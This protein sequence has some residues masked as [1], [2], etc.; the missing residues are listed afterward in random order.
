MKK[1]VLSI[2]FLT[3]T[4]VTSACTNPSMEDGLSRLDVALAEL[5]AAIEAINIPQMQEDLTAMNVMADQILADAQAAQLNFEQILSEL[6]QA[7]AILEGIVQ[8]SSSWAT[9]EDIAIIQAQVDEFEIGVDTLVAI[10]DYDHDGVINA[11][12]KCPD[13]PLGATVNAV[14]C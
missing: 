11:L 3:V 1:L 7:E 2:V 12:D 8:D 14:G 13:T 4:L 5:A 9:S 10:A 6:D